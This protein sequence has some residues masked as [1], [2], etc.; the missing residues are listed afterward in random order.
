MKQYSDQSVLSKGYV[1]SGRSLSVA[2]QTIFPIPC[3]NI[4]PLICHFITYTMHCVYMYSCYN[5]MHI[6]KYYLILANK[7][8]YRCV[9][10]NALSIVLNMA[11]IMTHLIDWFTEI[12][13]HL[14]GSLVNCWLLNDS[15]W[16]ILRE[17]LVR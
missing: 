15:W 16:Q 8:V 17:A 6:P 13:T 12:L 14:I 10:I 2:K 11:E 1:M 7:A 9:I 3:G 4:W 5:V